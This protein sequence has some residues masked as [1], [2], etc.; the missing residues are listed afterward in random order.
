[1]ENIIGGSGPS[2]LREMEASFVL[3][4]VDQVNKSPKL[5]GVGGLAG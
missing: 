2:S 3:P 5:R 4:K 1:M